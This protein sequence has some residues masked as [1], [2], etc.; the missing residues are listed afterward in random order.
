MCVRERYDLRKLIDEIRNGRSAYKECKK[1][2]VCI[3][4]RFDII[5]S[6]L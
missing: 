2:W 3:L 1:S 4:I 6:R 5:G